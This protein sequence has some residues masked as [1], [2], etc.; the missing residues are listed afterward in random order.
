MKFKNFIYKHW[1]G[2][3]MILS[4]LFAVVIHILFCLETSNKYL[5][6][7]WGAGDILAYA[8][9]VALGLLAMWQNKKQQEE[10]DKAQN[11]LENISIRANELNMINKIVE[12][13]SNRIQSL[14][15]AMDELTNACDP[16]AVGLAIAKEGIDNIP[17]LLGLAEL[18]KVVDNSFVNVGR[19]MRQ[20]TELQYNDSNPLNQAYANLYLCAKNY[21]S[22]LRDNKIDINDQRK[23]G[24]MS[25]TLAHFRDEFLKERE[26]YLTEQEKKLKKVLFEDLSLKEIQAMYGEQ[27][28]N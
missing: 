14:K 25:G 21:I 26:N 7:R 13:E 20:D 15:V 19:Y 28:D 3:W 27:K 11:R 18:E 17:S 23:M 12:F 10:N 9:T 4:V 24:A 1:I 8:S 16:Q 5:V 2:C 22:D 6:A